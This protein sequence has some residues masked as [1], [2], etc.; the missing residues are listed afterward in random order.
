VPWRRARRSRMEQ[1]DGTCAKRIRAPHRLR[2]ED[3]WTWGVGSRTMQQ[4]ART[5]GRGRERGLDLLVGHDRVVGSPAV[6]SNRRRHPS[7]EGRKVA[8]AAAG[9]RG[10]VTLV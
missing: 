2:G 8:A 5:P 1:A 3:S 7:G 9:G 4:L 6:S 10:K